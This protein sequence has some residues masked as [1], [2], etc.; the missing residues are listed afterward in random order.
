MHALQASVW[1]LIG[2]AL[3]GCKSGSYFP[4]DE[5]RVREYVVTVKPRTPDGEEEKPQRG[6]A[7]LTTLPRRMLG[8]IEVT[9]EVVQVGNRFAY[10]FYVEDE[11]GVR[12]VA[13]QGFQESE[14]EVLEER[15]D[16]LRYPLERGKRWKDFQETNFTSPAIEIEGETVVA[17]ENETVKVP[18]GTFSGC[19]KLV[20][21]GTASVEVDI[22]AAT[23]GQAYDLPEGESD[24]DGFGASDRA[25]E[26]VDT[27]EVEF[28]LESE[29]WFAPGVG[30]IK[31]VQKEWASSKR[32]ADG[33]VMYEL[34]S[35]KKM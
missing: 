21:K 29:S 8:G 19:K 16:M 27:E 26:A 23:G 20:F 31:F 15:A 1:L 33:T 25:E 32:V 6:Q 3:S 11:I 30:L 28:E 34:Q 13:R 7:S 5:H 4:L 12:L 22:G 2:L 14:P 17:G 9:P 35:D 10:S 18:A 24:G